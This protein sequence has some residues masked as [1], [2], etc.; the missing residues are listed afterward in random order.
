MTRCALDVR[1]RQGDFELACELESSERV[2]GLFGPSGA[3]K[4]SLLRVIAG[5]SPTRLGAYRDRRALRVRQ[6]ARPARAGPPAAYRLWYFSS[7]GCFRISMCATTSD[8]GAWFSRRRPVRARFD[9]VVDMLDIGDLLGR[10]TRD[11]SGGESQRVAI[12]RALLSDPSCCCW[13]SRWLRSMRPA[14]ARCCPIS[15]A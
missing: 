2:I 7:R 11:L 12:G 14:S 4:S 10:R 8:Y 6:C 9:Q 15:S 3:G 13:T 1:L 5:L